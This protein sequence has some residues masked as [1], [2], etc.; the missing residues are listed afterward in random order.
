MLVISGACLLRVLSRHGLHHLMEGLRS[1]I[2]GLRQQVESFRRFAPPGR[3]FSKIC[4]ARS[5][6]FEG[7][8]RQVEGLRRPIKDLQGQ[9]ESFRRFALP[10]ERFVPPDRRFALPNKRLAPPGRRFVPP[11]E[12]F[13][14]PGRKRYVNLLRVISRIE[15]VC[16]TIPVR[17]NFWRFHYVGLVSKTFFKSY[18]ER[19]HRHFVTTFAHTR[20][21]VCSCVSTLLKQPN[22]E[23][24]SVSKGQ[25]KKRLGHVM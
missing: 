11:D 15:L 25:A 21:H 24:R 10:D 20:A 4:A 5:K 13:A 8:R 6:V 7:L 2:E 16:R 17:V 1:Q 23:D 19:Q 22:L 14:L 3:K 12:R 18:S 9:V